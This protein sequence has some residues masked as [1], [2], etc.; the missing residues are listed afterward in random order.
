MNQELQETLTTFIRLASGLLAVAYLA[1]FA[2]ML[3]QIY[4]M[5]I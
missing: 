5:I 4:Q 2:W 1:G 3:V